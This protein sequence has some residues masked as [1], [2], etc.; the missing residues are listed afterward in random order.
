M[1]SVLT[2]SANGIETSPVTRG[3][4]LLE[5]FLGTP[6]PQPP[7]DVPAI[8]PDIRGTTTIRD[9][10]AKHRELPTCYSC[11]QKIDPPGFAL[12]NFNPIGQWRVNYPAPAKGKPVKIDPSGTTDSGQEFTN[13]VEFKKLLANKEDLVVRHLTTKLLSY[14]T[15]R[16]MGA[17]EREELDELLL[18]SAKNGNH[19][20]D[21]MHLVVQSEIFRRP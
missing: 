14:A 12:E 15:G 5:N 11:H 17:L 1:G 19:I 16:Q 8:D 13:I 9:Q 10:L 3:V 20:R 6:P 21:L 2:V 4:W 7:D 18:Q